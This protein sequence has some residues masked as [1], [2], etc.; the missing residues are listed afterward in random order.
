MSWKVKENSLNFRYRSFLGDS[1]K[2]LCKKGYMPIG[3]IS[4]DQDS[5]DDC[6]EIIYP[7]CSSG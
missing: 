3:N 7:R 6:E 5:P 2:C 1:P 4:M